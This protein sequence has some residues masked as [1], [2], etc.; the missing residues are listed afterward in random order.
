M[1]I[2]HFGQFGSVLIRHGLPTFV[3][4]VLYCV[5]L[6][7]HDKL[8]ELAKLDLK[9]A[10]ILTNNYIFS[11]AIYFYAQSF[12][13]ST[14]SILAEYFAL[15]E[16]M[17]KHE[18]EQKLKKSYGHKLINV[19]TGMMRILI[20]DDTRRYEM[21][22]GKETD[23]FIQK[24]RE[25]IQSLDLHTYTEEDMIVNFRDI[26]SHNYRFYL[27][28]KNKESNDEHPGWE[29]LRQRFAN[30]KTK[31]LKY[32]TISWILAP[33]LENVEQYVMYPS[34]S[35]NYN[36]V[37]FFMDYGNKTACEMLDEMISELIDIVPLVW[38]KIKTLTPE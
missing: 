6:E 33:V 8:Y 7:L 37:E 30:P 19:S 35:V 16:N 20:D 13:K 23:D 24:P 18:I 36:N 28:T 17:A 14:K 22:G 27:K 32:M 5:V 29:Y 12:E 3:S 15:F 2:A 25:A 21:A 38:E 9:A 10:N 34:K 11:H 1:V 26:V 4:L 31:Y